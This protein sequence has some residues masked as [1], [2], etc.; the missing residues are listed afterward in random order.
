MYANFTFFVKDEDTQALKDVLNRHLQRPIEDVFP[1]Y[2]PRNGPLWVCPQHE[3]GIVKVRVAEDYEEAEV[4]VKDLQ[5]LS[6]KTVVDYGS[7]SSG[8]FDRYWFLLS[9]GEFYCEKENFT[10]ELVKYDVEKFCEEE[11]KDN[12]YFMNNIRGRCNLPPKPSQYQ[13]GWEEGYKE[14]LAAKH[15]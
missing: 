13:L 12:S 5:M 7:V 15:A 8:Q 1:D 3:G 14:G 11:L 4:L 2:R 10:S 6:Y 9:T